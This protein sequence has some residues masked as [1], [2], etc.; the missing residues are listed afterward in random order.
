MD[1]K[2]GLILVICSMI[3][4][5][6]VGKYW[7]VIKQVTFPFVSLLIILAKGWKSLVLVSGEEREKSSFRLLSAS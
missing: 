7:L 3:L 6:E 1:A 2:Q 5:S 4:A